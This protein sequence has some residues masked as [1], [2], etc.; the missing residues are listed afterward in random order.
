[1]KKKNHHNKLKKKENIRNKL[2]KTKM[3][4][5]IIKTSKKISKQTQTKKTSNFDKHKVH[6]DDSSGRQKP[7]NVFSYLFQI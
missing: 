4:K 2:G 6:S 3:S 7:S 1:M 5:Q